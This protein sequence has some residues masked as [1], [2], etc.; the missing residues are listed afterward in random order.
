MPQTQEALRRA[1]RLPA[2]HLSE[3]VVASDE[4]VPEPALRW[5][6]ARVSRLKNGPRPSWGRMRDS[7]AGI[8]SS[9]CRDSRPSG[10]AAMMAAATVPGSWPPTTA[11]AR[12]RVQGTMVRRNV[13][14]RRCR[15]G[16]ELPAVIRPTTPNAADEAPAPSPIVCARRRCS[17]VSRTAAVS[18]DRTAN[19]LRSQGSAASPSSVG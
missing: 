15:R 4:L 11:R 19:T 6:T 8:N 18:P 3:V 9:S 7:V 13:V 5:M 1:G 17:R 2:L 12:I 14:N 16:G 10:K